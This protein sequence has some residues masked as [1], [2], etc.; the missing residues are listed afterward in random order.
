MHDLV[1]TALVGTANVP[2]DAPAPAEIEALLPDGSREQRLLWQAGSLAVY[3]EAGR[4][5][6]TMN[7]PAPR[8]TKW[9]EKRRRRSR[10]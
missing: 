10:R 6:R 8:R 7:V 2:H 9:R 1:R 5:P 3:G 4:L